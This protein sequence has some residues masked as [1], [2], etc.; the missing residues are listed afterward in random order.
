MLA[1]W[2]GIGNG[3]TGRGARLQVGRRG[4]QEEGKAHVG[5][6]QHGGAGS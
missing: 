6:D 4:P 5:V 2:L 3:Q 1:H